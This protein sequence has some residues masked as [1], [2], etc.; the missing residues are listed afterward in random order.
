MPLSVYKMRGYEIDPDF[1][2]RNPKQWSAGLDDWVYMLAE[3]SVSEKDIFATV[4]RE[5]TCEDKKTEQ[6]DLATESEGEG[7]LSQV[8]IKVLKTKTESERSLLHQ[9]NISLGNI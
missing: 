7:Q 4:E 8:E 5:V 2:T 3:M 9:M 6:V 1:T